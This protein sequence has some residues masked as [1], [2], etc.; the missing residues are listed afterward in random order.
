MTGNRRN[1]DAAVKI[2]DAR[3]PSIFYPIM[4]MR[5]FRKVYPKASRYGH[6]AVSQGIIFDCGDDILLSDSPSPDQV[7]PKDRQKD[8]CRISQDDSQR[9][10]GQV[11]QQRH[12]TEPQEYGHE[13]DLERE[14]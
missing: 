9:R 5:P 12:F 2:A 6:T 13:Y 10:K 3:I 14:A 11:F 7:R 8:Q 4:A 1:S